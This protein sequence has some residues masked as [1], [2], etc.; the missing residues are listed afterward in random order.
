MI[1]P[2]DAAEDDGWDEEEADAP[3]NTSTA[4]AAESDDKGEADDDD[5][6]D[7]D[8]DDGDSDEEAGD[9]AGEERAE[10][11]D[12]GGA[13]RRRRR[14]RRSEPPVA[15]DERAQTALDFVSKIVTEMEMDC[16]VVCGGAAVSPGDWVLGD[17]D[18]VV[19]V[20]QAAAEEVFVLALEKV[21]AE[22]RTRDELR[23]G[24]S[25]REVFDRFGVL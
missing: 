1:D 4:V 22:S 19:V 25:L 14:K 9:E 2:T 7:F 11:D 24:R 23:A 12:A 6:D 20:P 17:A 18:G 21:A 13:K 10:G 16:R 15:A 8:D 3:N 5:D